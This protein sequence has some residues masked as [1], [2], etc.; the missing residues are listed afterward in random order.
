MEFLKNFFSDD[1]Q[2]VGLCA[3]KNKKEKI[4]SFH[5]EPKPSFKATRF[6]YETLS[7]LNRNQASKQQDLS[8]KLIR[9][10]TSFCSKDF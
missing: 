5:F 4:Y 8:M 6:V 7:T 1:N 3:F 10:K 9:Q 2:V